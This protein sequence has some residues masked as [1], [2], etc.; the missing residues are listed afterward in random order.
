MARQRA[1]EISYVA[2]KDVRDDEGGAIGCP[3]LKRTPAEY[4][5]LPTNAPVCYH[6][7]ISLGTTYD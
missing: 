3:T 1:T 6:G 7:V 5:P 4:M 2:S